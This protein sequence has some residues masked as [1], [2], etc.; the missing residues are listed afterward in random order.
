MTALAKEIQADTNLSD[1]QAQDLDDVVFD[2]QD[3]YAEPDDEDEVSFSVAGQTSSPEFKN[4]F[5]NSK[6]VDDAGKPVVVYHG[7]SKPFSKVN[8]R[9]GAQGVFWVTS[10]KKAIEDGEI[11]AAGTGTILELYAKIENP[12]GWKEYDKYSLDELES[13]Y[14]YD[15]V[16]LPNSDGTFEAIVFNPN[17]IKSAT[18]NK[19]GFSTE[20]DNINLSSSAA[21]GGMT[22]AA[23][24]S[25]IAKDIFNQEVDVYQSIDDAPDYIKTQAK[26]EG[27]EGVEGF[28]DGR[29]NRVALIANNLPNDKRAQAVARHELIGHYGLENMVGKEL[30][31]R[32][33][34]RVLTAEKAG[35]KA[36]IDAAKLVDE[37]QPGL[38]DYRRGK[39]IIAVMA[40]R[41]LHNNIV[42]RVM[43]AI[44]KFLKEH[45]FTKE[46]ITDVRIAQLLRDATEY[47]KAKEKG[48]ADGDI[49]DFSRA[50]HGTPHRFDKFSTDNIGTGEGAQAFGYGLYFAS[51]KAIAESYRQNIPLNQVIKQ[52]QRELPDDADFDEV[53][54][55]V[56]TGHFTK[57]QDRILKALDADGWL[58]F[59]YAS[60]AIS[61]AYRDIENYDP[62]QELRDA[63]NG[64]SQLYEVEI[65]NDNEYLLWDKPYKDQPK[66]VKEAIENAPKSVLQYGEDTTGENIYRRLQIPAIQKQAGMTPSYQTDKNASEYL[67]SLGISGIKYLDG[68]SRAKG[69]GNYNYVVFDDKKVNIEKTYF[70]NRKPVTVDN[71]D[72][73]LFR[74]DE[75]GR[76]QLAPTGNAYDLAATVTQ[77]LSDKV[78]FGMASPE[79]RKQIR[80][81]K[82]DMAKAMDVA[83]G[84]AKTMN[85][86]SP[87]ERA[88][89]SDVVEQMVKTGVTPPDHVMKIAAAMSQTM[90]AQTSELVDL[91]MLAKD[92]AERWRGKYLPR[93]YN[94][95]KDP[96]LDTL[97]KKLLRTAL[98][99]R[100]LGGGSLK[101]RGL[102]QEV[103]VDELPA[104]EQLGWEVR[105]P[106][107]K[108]DRQGRLELID[109]EKARD[110]EKV[111][112]WR[113][114]SPEEREAMGENRDALFRFVMGYTA[115]QNDIALGR[116]FDAIAKNQEWTRSRA[117]EG[118]TKI[119]DADIEGTGGVKRYGNLAGLYVRD[120]IIQHITQYEES[121]E[122]L[123]FYRKALSFWKAGKTVLNPVSHMNN[124][125][126]NLTMAHFAGVSYWDTH[127]YIGALRDFVKG[128]KY[129][130][131]AKDVGL[132][133]GDITRTELLANMPADI[134][135]LMGQ[136]DSKITKTSQMTYKVLTFGLVRPMSAAYR[137]ED[138]FFK[139]LIYR[140]ARENGA[141]PDDA[142]DYATRYIFNYD[143]LPKTARNVR[144]AAI[145]FFAYTY[146]AVPALAHTLANYPW[147]FAAP[148]LAI[149]GLNAIAYG[150]IAGDDDDDLAEKMAKG[151]ELEAEE[152]KNLPPWM[153]GKSALGTEKTIRLGN[154]PRTGLP[155]YWDV[156]RFI[157]G[158]DM[159]DIN[160]QVEGT[161]LPAPIMPS[162][163]V[164]TTIAA[165]L[166]NKDTFTG[167]DVV[168]TNDTGTEKAKKRGE[169]LI[170][171]LSPAIAPTGYH[172][173]RLMQAGADM[174]DTTIETPFKDYTGKGK[175]GL[176]VQAKY[177]IP[178]TLG[179]K[180][181]PT[182][183]EL[184]AD[185]AQG[186]D[187]KEIGTIRGEIRQ[188]ARLLDKGA[189]SQRSYDETVAAAE[190]KMDRII[191][192]E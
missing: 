160:N 86:M 36:I 126:S 12:A 41:N 173:D 145:P 31:Q 168:D 138:D 144:D 114:F 25:A 9:K 21:P 49:A 171:Q 130:D 140:D 134:K 174:A 74:R 172:A 44:R 26:S 164:L 35:N 20:N 122:L 129:L 187:R 67:N 191:N 108:K 150:L 148:A 60:Q 157:P 30:M 70:S 71:R 165:M 88:L 42:K 5:G 106:L 189:I 188:A 34:A 133:T 119:P 50:F 180:V 104:F 13:R 113:D 89:V 176:P 7:T 84:V 116:M 1:Q 102:F 77:N 167:K 46:D 54:D 155:L 131:E 79:L 147:R 105:D 65:P 103:T 153:Q 158:G 136:Q 132:L 177:A 63:V 66:T 33:S 28:Y 170:K 97:G 62:S 22:V 55:L 3:K 149:A 141:S 18:K 24:R 186:Q 6:T 175:D 101:G 58:G 162:N 10:N 56:G 181:K 75:L 146:K 124:V 96:A 59:D 95:D 99:V 81:F 184:S 178:Q 14:G 111:V 166:W 16:I 51:N 179:I 163:P 68:S 128:S 154:D 159:F 185:M 182:D 192:K 91:G 115:M 190:E 156:S 39:E 87:E 76:I 73:W 19:G 83:S 57:E 4:W 125:V 100:G 37:T 29:T 107:W 112:I 23:V 161:P 139:Y 169:W 17:Q 2:A 123:K 8:M 142:V 152:R 72:N 183:L 53:M 78:G 48:I 90:D 69:D 143:D 82:A 52:F 40:E 135:A 151:K 137:F 43:D 64:S 38:S 120:D 45:G 109:A 92:T 80:H 98:P 127:K 94:R 117:S 110:T 121:G 47:L 118:Y 11:G 61:A 32:L 85:K 93:F 15:G 27:A